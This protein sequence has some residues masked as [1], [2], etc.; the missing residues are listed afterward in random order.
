MFG[1]HAGGPSEESLCNPGTF[2]WTSQNGFWVPRLK[3]IPEADGSSQ[4]Q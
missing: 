2:K 1:Y 3:V 4:F